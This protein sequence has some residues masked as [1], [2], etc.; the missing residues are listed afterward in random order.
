LIRK[1][2]SGRP[3]VKPVIKVAAAEGD[4]IVSAVPRKAGPGKGDSWVRKVLKILD[5]G[6]VTG[7]ADDD[8]SGIAT[9]SSVGAQSG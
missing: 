6:L 2:H 1:K 8:P 3:K 5:P 7:A 9:Y 4:T